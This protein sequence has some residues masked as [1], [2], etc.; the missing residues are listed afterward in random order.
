MSTL[1]G[2]TYRFADFALEPGERRLSRRGRLIPLTPKAFE[3]LVLLVQ[4]AGHVVSK[5]AVMAALW[6]GR[7]VMESNLTKHIWMLRQTL[8][9]GAGG[10][11]CIETVPKIGYR[12]VALVTREGPG[13]AS[14]PARLDVRAVAPAKAGPL[15]SRGRLA[16]AIA[17]AA[18]VVAVGFYATRP[19]APSFASPR[20]AAV[21][22][23]KFDNLSRNP[24]DVWVGPALAETLGTEIGLAGRLRVI[25]GELARV[26]QA[27][28]PAPGAGGY[29]PPS[30][31]F[32]RRRLGADYVVSGGYLVF[33]EGPAAAVRLDLA[34]QNTRD[35]AVVSLTR[36]GSLAD[37]PALVTLIGA[38]LRRDLGAGGGR[39]EDVKLAVN[40][41]PP[42]AEVMRHMGFGLDALRRYDAARAR[43]EFLDAVAQ[44]P[45]YA[46]AH[47][48]L[49][50]AWSALGYQAKARAAAQQAAAHAAD[51]PAPM[52]LQIEAQGQTA[53]FD[54]PGAIQTLRHLITLR[55]GD[56]EARLQLIDTL[57]SAGK[58]GDAAAALAA[59]RPLPG[60]GENDPRIEL[61]AA[62]VAA[63]RD[64]DTARGKHAARALVQA[65]A[66]NQVGLAA[67]AEV[68][69]GAAFTARDPKAAG[70]NLRRALIDY[71]RVG[72]PHGEAWAEQSLG[73]LYADSDPPGARAAY[74]R[75]LAQ[76]QAIG[77]LAGAA[78]VY[79]DLAIMLWSSGDRDAAE[80]A[81]NHALDLRR[82]TGDKAGEAWALAALAVARS[83][84][85]AGDAVVAQF[86]QAIALDTAAG[87]Q[88]HLGFSLFSLADVLR[89]RGELALAQGI[90]AKAQVV[91]GALGDAEKRHVA[92]FECAQIALDRG[93]VAAARAGLKGARQAG[94]AMT[95]GNADMLEG[96]I[97]AGEGRPAEA[98]VHLEAARRAFA[99][100]EM[101]TGEAVASSLL[102]LSYAALDRP[103]ARDAAAQRAVEL[104]GRIT[105]REEVF[106]ADIAAA[107]L[108]GR[109][110]QPE[111]AI[112]TLAALADDAQRRRWV[113]LSL[114]AR[115][116]ALDVLV[117]VGETVRARTLRQD[118]AASARR[119]GFVW[120]LQR[121]PSAGAA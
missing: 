72:N 68:Q 16:W 77:D 52:R 14:A 51:L 99:G 46:P 90:C 35:G 19:P 83:D 38:D 34:L 105:E 81:A 89:M 17:L 37:L 107:Q 61:A 54:W 75:S 18:L 114:D 79:S 8:G 31:S 25:P 4:S 56:P 82:Q 86:R 94:D 85:S 48:Y 20:G 58:P 62:A 97:A 96:Q 87:A 71:R 110:G 104:R 100:A 32:L 109:M 88:A 59:L 1:E 40:L 84:E 50:Q 92:D 91:Y 45:D 26:A 73:N 44:A 23:A 64:D 15:L 29:A 47:V 21:S 36:S 106:G 65:R 117:R 98:A 78:K 2:Q 66:N 7:F 102:A 10:E 69:L 53:R 119:S 24:S 57:L 6:P 39:A 12:F 33:G 74:E 121:L 5:E 115:L 28:L 70:E 27:G 22:L 11:G 41:Q 118:L 9:D 116:A 113:G 67:D 101:T 120:V 80:T 49:A 93:D 111:Q 43:D 103:A 108:R 60:Y 13:E 3:L 112:V 30:L 42:S 63:A 55:S 95:L 76:Y